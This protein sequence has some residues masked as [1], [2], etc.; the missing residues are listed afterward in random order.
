M[1]LADDDE[2]DRMLFRDA[3][4]EINPLVSVQTVNDG[5]ELMNYLATFAVFLPELLFLDLNMPLKNGFQCLEEIR[6][7]EL[8]QDL[9]IIIYSTTANPKEVEEVYNKGAN[10]FIKKPSSFT[11]LRRILAEVFS[12]DLKQY[13]DTIQKEKF[14][15]K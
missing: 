5:E 1:L 9:L 8:L 14:V 12:L 6:Q 2:D 4:A 15:V 11:E 13:V 7:N 3:V 10:L